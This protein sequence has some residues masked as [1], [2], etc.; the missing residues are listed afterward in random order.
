MT[1]RVTIYHWLVVSLT[2]HA[3]VIGLFVLIMGPRAPREAAHTKLRIDLMGMIANRQ[4]EERRGGSAAAQPVRQV[5][6]AAPRRTPSK[7]ATKE[8]PARLER[9]SDIPAPTDKTTEQAEP[10]GPSIP[11]A[12]GAPGQGPSQ[13]GQTIAHRDADADGTRQYLSRLSKRLQTNLVY[14]EEARKSGIEGISTIAFT[15]EESGMIKAN[16]L[17]VRKSSGYAALDSNAMKSAQSSA[18]FEKPPK[19]LN[20]SIAVAF[21]VDMAGSRGGRASMR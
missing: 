7:D 2:L 19:E 18:P 14:P 6:Q 17:R 20:V 3:V 16:S 1:S 8:N 21:T 4:V 13:R 10:S 5:K 11:A 12:S 15:I 9:P